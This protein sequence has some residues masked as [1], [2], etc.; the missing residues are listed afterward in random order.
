MAENW[1]DEIELHI[2]SVAQHGYGVGRWQGRAVFAEGALPGEEVRVRLHD[3]QRSFARGVVSRVLKAAPE[4]VPSPCPLEDRCGAAG[5]RWVEYDAQ[6]RFKAAIL[7]E[8]MRH[9]GGID[10]EVAAVHGM[11]ALPTGTGPRCAAG[12]GWDYR[13]TAEMH[14]ANGRLG[15]FAP[16]S[17]QVADTPQCCL[18]HPLLD[19]ALAALA[20]LLQPES[21]I[22]SVTVRCA[23]STGK[24]LA[25][26]E[27]SG[28]FDKLA[29]RWMERC[30]ELSGVLQRDRSRTKLLRGDDHLIQ[31][32]H[33]LR[34]HV[35]AGSF[36]QVNDR[37]TA[38]L[39]ER[40]RDL[41]R[42]QPGERMLDLF[43]GVGTFALPLARAGAHM[44][45]VEVYA[46]A[47]ED[48]RRSAA[49]NELG[50]VEWHAGPVEAILGKLKG[51]FDGAVL[52]PPRRGCEPAA[53]QQLL[54][55]RPARIV[56]VSCHPGTLARDCKML[57]EGGY[58][59]ERA[60][61][62]DLFPQTHH[63][64]SIVLLRT[65]DR[66]SAVSFQKEPE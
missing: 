48:A 19:K 8:Q 56:Y 38:L 40:V 28:A 6:L 29:A 44:T 53:L 36:F 51:R 62:I 33:G 43:C 5:W 41:L 39:I 66:P 30:P 12:P 25:V 16:H 22:R 27:G 32:L 26:L 9:L 35:G 18:H 15:Y 61:M 31:E 45:G 49:L 23:P 47:I 4:R 2:T 58:D 13:T 54:R 1:P 55:L 60:E 42:P 57:R 17:R 20:A 64:E 50:P 52:D 59:V 24:L 65:S 14:V 3:R 46:P 10:V 63:V 34:W 37:Q 7:E 11:R 21:R